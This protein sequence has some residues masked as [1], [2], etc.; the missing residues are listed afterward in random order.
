MGINWDQQLSELLDEAGWPNDG[1]KRETL[2][3]HC[4]TI[5]SQLEQIP[6]QEALVSQMH[7]LR[8]AIITTYLDMVDHLPA[9]DWPT[10]DDKNR[11][12]CAAMVF[13]LYQLSG[14]WR[15]HEHVLSA[16]LCKSIAMSFLTGVKIGY[17]QGLHK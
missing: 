15:P 11:D 12:I 4:E 16:M 5:I 13:A 10:A 7:R 8:P 1:P 3:Q 2:I 14:T 17:S 6:G 9:V